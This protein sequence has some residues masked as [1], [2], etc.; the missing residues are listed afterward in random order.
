MKDF[1]S[2]F[3]RSEP[4]VTPLPTFEPTKDFAAV[5]QRFLN[6]GVNRDDLFQILEESPFEPRLRE[7]AGRTLLERHHAD[8][9]VRELNTIIV[10]THETSVCV[11]AGRL[12]LTRATHKDDLGQVLLSVD[13]LKVQAARIILES[14]PETHDLVRCLQIPEVADEALQRL[15]S[16]N[17][18]RSTLL[19]LIRFQRRF[20][21]AVR[22]Y[23]QE[24]GQRA[25]FTPKMVAALKLLC[26]SQ[27]TNH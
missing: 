2:R 7:Y 14:D 1:F 13:S 21:P 19:Y 26:E 11:D 10:K 5:W 22:Q 25:D 15:L 23:L 3:R 4:Q 27:H 8:L 12:V 24:T 17:T 20:A 18:P 9:T 6:I 16:P